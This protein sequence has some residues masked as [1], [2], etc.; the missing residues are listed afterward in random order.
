MHGAVHAEASPG[1]TAPPGVAR[2]A[3]NYTLAL[4]CLIAVVNYIDRQVLSILLEEV[5]HDLGASDTQM[6]L[7]NGFV[8]AS[9]YIIAGIPIA[10]W[11]DSGSRRNVLVICIAGWSAAT[12]LCGLTRNYWQLALARM[13]V[14]AGE[15]GASPSS[16]SL[17][18]DLFPQGSRGRALG[19]WSA[20]NSA[21][22]GLG[23]LLGGFL[24]NYMSWRG[25]FVV[26]G[27]P[28]LALAMLTLF[29]VRE[30]P[31]ESGD[32]PAP[33]FKETIRHLAAIPSYR[34]AIAVTALASFCGSGIFGW[35][36]TFLIRIHNMS[37]AAV[38]AWT[39]MASVG[40]LVAAHLMAGLGAPPV[41][42]KHARAF[43]KKPPV[44]VIL[45]APLVVAFA[46]VGSQ[47]VAI[48][49]FFALKLA[50]GLHMVPVYTVALTL[51]PSNMRGIAGFS[52][53]VAVNLA[54]AGLGPLFVGVMNDLLAPQLGVEAIR[55][56]MA[57]LVCPLFL[58]FATAL[59][60]TRRARA[61]FDEH[62]G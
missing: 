53:A 61:D 57:L 14:A 55:Y 1:G 2:R 56:S 45:T 18:A 39:G 19:I 11:V 58:A 22:I 44:S 17:I 10:R 32:A 30:P 5:K 12:I 9:V 29:T 20:S 25:V 16:Q 13:G 59:W 27:L 26:V 8:F 7:L 23:L 38:G 48:A 42:R 34:M 50:L 28:G 47:G 6:G 40:A 37:V 49:I 52:I 31:R 43:L 46:F 41:G 3:A 4:L 60:A 24:S 51:A 36:P 33:A 62:A 35:L 15:A 54:G 21:G